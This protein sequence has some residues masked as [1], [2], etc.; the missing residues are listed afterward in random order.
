MSSDSLVINNSSRESFE[1]CTMNRENRVNS[2]IVN[3]VTSNDKGKKDHVEETALKNPSLLYTDGHIAP[4]GIK[5]ATTLRFG[6]LTNNND[7]QS[8]C[9]RNN[10]L[11]TEDIKPRLNIETNTTLRNGQTQFLRKPDLTTSQPEVF[12]P[13]ISDLRDNVQNPKNIIPELSG[14]KF[15]RFGENTRLNKT[16]LG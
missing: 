4:S 13:Q 3:Y 11:F 12:M 8:L 7:P 6:T 16:P 15:S 14:D 9:A 10:T 1:Q 5:D 2:S